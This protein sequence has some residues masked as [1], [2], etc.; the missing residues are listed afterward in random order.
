[1]SQAQVYQTAIV[2]IIAKPSEGDAKL[3]KIEKIVGLPPL[4]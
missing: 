1:M 4:W 3:L 2:A